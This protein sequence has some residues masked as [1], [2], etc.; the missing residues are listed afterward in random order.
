MQQEPSAC[1]LVGLAAVDWREV[2]Q[3][4]VR[5]AD[6]RRRRNARGRRVAAALRPWE[7]PD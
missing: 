4:H 2:G 3:G 6:G 5:V 1:V 7:A